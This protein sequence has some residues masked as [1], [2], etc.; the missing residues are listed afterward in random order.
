[1]SSRW[2]PAISQAS[3]AARYQAIKS[4]VLLCIPS[5]STGKFPQ[6]FSSITPVHVDG[7]IGTRTLMAA[8]GWIQ[9]CPRDA[10]KARCKT[11]GTA[12]QPRMK[13]LVTHAS[14]KKH[15]NLM[16]AAGSKIVQGSIRDSL[17]PLTCL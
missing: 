7:A 13:L 12:I 10:T 17:Q 5:I 16:S 15:L 9:Q 2:P 11:C 3:T 14:G 1:M 4:P 6:C 8:A